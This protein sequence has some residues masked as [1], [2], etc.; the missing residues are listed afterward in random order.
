MRYCLTP[1]EK[2]NYCACSVLQA[3]F[4]SHGIEISQED[5]FNNLTPSEKGVILIDEK[6]SNFIKQNGFDYEFYFHNETPF[7]EPEIILEQDKNIFLGWDNH[8]RLLTSFSD[9]KVK[10]LDPKD[11]KEYSKDLRE[12]R[13]LMS[14]DKKGLFGIIT[15]NGKN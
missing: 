5:I 4:R 1:Q 8:L 13:H 11:A 12:I 10:F 15:K 14:K 3:I 2:E 9:P 6:F 7:N